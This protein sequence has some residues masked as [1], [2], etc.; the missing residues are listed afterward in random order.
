MLKSFRINRDK[1]IT[2]TALKPSTISGEHLQTRIF[3]DVILIICHHVTHRSL[4]IYP[5][6]SLSRAQV[7]HFAP[8]MKYVFVLEQGIYD[9]LSYTR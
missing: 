2:R 6:G 9:N 5:Y 8:S 7:K 3:R 4:I 1:D